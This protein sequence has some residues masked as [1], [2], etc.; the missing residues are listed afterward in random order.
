[1]R[2]EDVVHTERARILATLIRLVGDFDLAE[3]ALQDA[4]TAALEHWPAG[5]VPTNPAAWLITTAR[6]KAID[7]LR[8][9]ARL[10]QKSEELVRYI[11]LSTQD[12]APV[13]E[14]RLRLIFTCCHPA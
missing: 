11:E 12:E 14:D 5:G 10:A 13:P 8:R 6:H 4:L 3:D 1:M 9:D 7:R 2:I